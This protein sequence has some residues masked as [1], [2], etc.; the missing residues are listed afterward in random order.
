MAAQLT[1]SERQVAWAE[2]IRRDVLTRMRNRADESERS[3]ANLVEP[4]PHILAGARALR[5]AADRAEAEQSSAAWWIDHRN[6]DSKEIAGEVLGAPIQGEVPGFMEI[7][8]TTP[9]PIY[10]FEAYFAAI[11]AVAAPT[12]PEAEFNDRLHAI[13]DAP[14][15]DADNNPSAESK[16]T[17][18]RRLG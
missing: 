13:L 12:M 2:Q 6:A 5:L 18:F 3:Q 15:G 9:H 17:E 4:Y 11:D 7:G 16:I 10:D 1:G 8:R 14:H